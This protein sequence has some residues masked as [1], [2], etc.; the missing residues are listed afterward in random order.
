VSLLDAA[1]AFGI[2]VIASA[3]LFQGRLAA[4]LPGFVREQMNCDND[5]EAA[6][7]F[8]RS[9]PDIT[10][11]LIGMSR[12]EHVAANLKVAA[13]RLASKE[14]WESLFTYAADNQR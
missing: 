1:H 8:T 4:R 2:A 5:A 7:Q 12:K 6:I 11:A 10:T 9:A 3:S 14:D 13:R